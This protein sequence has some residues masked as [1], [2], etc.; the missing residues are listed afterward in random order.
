MSTCPRPPIP[1]MRQLSLLPSLDGVPSPP[2]DERSKTVVLL[3]ALLIEAGR[4][5]SREAVD[6]GH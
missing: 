6:D 2:P 3:A 1:Q 4:P 5:A